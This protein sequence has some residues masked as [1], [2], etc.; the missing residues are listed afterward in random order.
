MSDSHKKLYCSFCPKSQRDVKMLIASGKPCG[1]FICDEC[2]DLCAV[3]CAEDRQR[4][5][6]QMH[7]AEIRERGT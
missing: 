6:E 5:R 4:G 1:A 2:V 3:I 7:L